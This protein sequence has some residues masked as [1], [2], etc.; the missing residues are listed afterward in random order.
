MILVVAYISGFVGSLLVW[1]FG[2]PRKDL[3][4]EGHC[5]LLLEQIDETKKSEYRLYKIMSNLGIFLISMS[6]LIQILNSF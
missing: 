1:F 4:K 2:L 5:S 3:N 6:F